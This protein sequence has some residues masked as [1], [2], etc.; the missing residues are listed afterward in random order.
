V[1][2][3]DADAVVD[4]AEDADPDDAAHEDADESD[5]PDAGDLPSPDLP[6]D[7]PDPEEIEAEAGAGS[8][9]DGD[10]EDDADGE[11]SSDSS[12]SESET[13]SA[14]RATGDT[15]GDLYCKMLVNLT[16]AM[17][18][19]HGKPD[20][21]PVDV[22][23]ARQADVDHHFDRLMESMG[24]GKDL[25][26]GQAV[27]LSTT[28]FVGGNLAAKTDVPAQMAGELGDLEF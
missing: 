18:E 24:M 4:A 10:T 14:D 23:A 27:V 8:D 17:I 13:P 2:D 9:D 6:D 15:M 7:G 20:A 5:Q 26:P 16:N 28:M 12:P 11:D 22:E 19:E 25:P 1:S 3:A 21:E